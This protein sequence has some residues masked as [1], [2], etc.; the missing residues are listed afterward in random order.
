MDQIG[1]E[2]LEIHLYGCGAEE[3]RGLVFIGKEDEGEVFTCLL[4]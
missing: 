2:F 4:P 3:S 1:G